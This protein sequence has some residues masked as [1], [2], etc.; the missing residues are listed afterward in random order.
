VV[1]S[2]LRTPRIAAAVIAL[3]ATA[4][5][6]E[7][8]VAAPSQRQR[9]G[10]VRTAQAP[11]A[12]SCDSLTAL[13]LPNTVITSAAVAPASGTTPASCRVHAQVPHPPAGDTENIDVWLP[14]Q[15]WNGRFQGVGGGGYAGGN[16]QFLALPVSQGYAAATTD[17]GHPGASGD[18]ALDANGHLNWQLIRDNAYLG[19]HDMTVVG[20]AVTAAFYGH[21]AHHAYW[22][23]CSTGGRQGLSEAQRYPDDYD[24]ILS[25]APAINW[26]RFI[27]AEFWPQLVMLQAGDFLPQCKFAAFQAAAVQACDQLGDRVQDGVIGD[28]LHCG[29]DPRTQIGKVTPCGT[30]TAQDAAVVGK[31]LAGPRTSTGEFLWYGLTPGSSFAGLALTASSASTTVGVPFPIPLT[32]I[33]IWLLQNPS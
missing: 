7:S 24:G 13:S 23:G 25:A 10:A 22:N 28:P 14:H 5:L 20:K 6:T 1:R 15:R 18:F 21:P 8:A 27:P 3:V 9:Q 32:H 17:T 30:I 16:P 11:M 26:S 31:I 2:R 29:F 4:M 19:V 33:G 12:G